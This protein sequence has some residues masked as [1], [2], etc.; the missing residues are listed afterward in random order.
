MFVAFC[1]PPPPP[2]PYPQQWRDGMGV[3]W[4]PPV[5]AV[6][7]CVDDNFWTVWSL[8]PNIVWWLCII[9]NQSVL[10]RIWIAVFKF[11]VQ[12]TQKDCFCYIFW[13]NDCFAV[14]RSL[15]TH[16]CNCVKS[17]L[18]WSRSQQRCKTSSS[19]SQDQG[20]SKCVKLHW[21]V[22]RVKVTANV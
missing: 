8:V 1:Y 9:V 19:D 5:R 21:V 17:G 6:R 13:T 2:T 20:H 15:M 18:L 16:H 22:V 11:K 4:N 12:V 10:R 7:V 3:Y 14:E